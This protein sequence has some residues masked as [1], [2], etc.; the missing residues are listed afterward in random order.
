MLVTR[1]RTQSSSLPKNTYFH[2]FFDQKRFGKCCRMFPYPNRVVSDDESVFIH[3]E[4]P[5]QSLD[6][7]PKTG[8]F[9]AIFRNFSE[10]YR[11]HR[12]F[13]PPV[14]SSKSQ[15]PKLQTHTP[16]PQKSGLPTPSE[17]EMRVLIKTFF[18][19]NSQGENR[20]YR[21]KKRAMIFENTF[22]SF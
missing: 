2:W 12:F 1:S 20:F 19:T 13:G 3:A 18:S 16:N 11:Q 14:A 9:K 15:N 5:S 6:F 10:Y 7:L 22:F 8:I 17:L 21:L 4:S